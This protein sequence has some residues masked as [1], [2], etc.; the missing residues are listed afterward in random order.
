MVKN[1]LF[2]S[3]I[4]KIDL[5]NIDNCTYLI[6][7]MKNIYKDNAFFCVDKEFNDFLKRKGIEEKDDFTE[8]LQ[9]IID[10]ESFKE[11]LKK[12][13]NCSPVKKYFLN[14]RRFIDDDDDDY[15]MTF[16]EEKDITS[17]EDDLLKD[18]FCTFLNFVQLNKNFLSKL[19]IF[20]YLPK[21][22]RAFVNPNMRINISP[23]FFEFSEKLEQN[24]RETIF[25]AYLF[26]IILH[27]LVHLFKFMNEKSFSFENIP[28]TPKKK[29][30]GKMF[31]NYLFKLPMIYYITYEQAIIINQP[32]NWNNLEILSEIFKEQKEWYDIYKEDKTKKFI[33]PSSEGKDSISFYL[34]FLD[35]GDNYK[36][37]NNEEIID[38]YYDFD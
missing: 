15:G 22:N 1:H 7:F 3:D 6:Y 32:E 21:Y 4:L 5:N 30:G 36:N 9:K 14:A 34:S 24:K 31:I 28:K 18:G 12:I 10:E 13:L 25:R 11:D 38:D 37:D 23:I 35:E 19:I 2:Y 17:G 8:I 16:I 26:I 33:R 20:K 27:E 29:E